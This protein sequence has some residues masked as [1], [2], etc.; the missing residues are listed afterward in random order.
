M[1][2]DPIWIT[3]KPPKHDRGSPYFYIVWEFIIDGKKYYRGANF[4]F[5][6]S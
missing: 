2:R 4:P 6:M 1:E 3:I 5:S